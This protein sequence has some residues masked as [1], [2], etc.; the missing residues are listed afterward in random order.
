MSMIS[1]KTRLASTSASASAMMRATSAGAVGVSMLAAVAAVEA[2]TNFMVLPGAEF[3]I[4][5]ATGSARVTYQGQ[6]YQVNAGHYLVNADGSISISAEAA[7]TVAPGL[8]TDTFTTLGAPVD[9]SVL[10]ASAD[11]GGGLFGGNSGLAIGAGVLGLAAV[12]VGGYFLFQSLSNDD[13]DNDSSSGG[14]SGG[15]NAAPVFTS[16][17]SGS[18]AQNTTGTIYT[19]IA[20]D[21]DNDTL[22]YSLVNANDAFSINSSSG[23]VSFDGSLVA[24][25]YATTIR[26][27]D[28]N[29]G[30]TDYA[31]DL[32][33][34]DGTV[35]PVTE[36]DEEDLETTDLSNSTG[37]LTIK[38]D[39]SDTDIVSSWSPNFG[40]NI[41][42]IDLEFGN[43]S[44]AGSTSDQTFTLDFDE[45]PSNVTKVYLD[46]STQDRFTGQDLDRPVEILTVGAGFGTIDLSGDKAV[47]LNLGSTTTTLSDIHLS[48]GM[49][50]L[51]VKTTSSSDVTVGGIDGTTDDYAAEVTLA[52]T[53]SGK[54]IVEDLSAAVTSVDASGSSGQTTV[55][56]L[57]T[58]N[59]WD[60]DFVTVTNGFDFTGGDNV[61]TLYLRKSQASDDVT[62][63]L[64]EG[65]E[66]F[67]AFASNTA[68][69]VIDAGLGT[70]T[71]ILKDDNNSTQADTYINFEA[72]TV[73]HSAGLV[74]FDLAMLKDDITYFSVI[75]G[76]SHDLELDNIGDGSEF[77]YL[78]SSTL[79]A[80]TDITLDA[81]SAG[82]TLEIDFKAVDGG[83]S[84]VGAITATNVSLLNVET[85][86]SL[87]ISSLDITGTAQL[88]HTA[89]TGSG[90]LVINGL[91]NITAIDALNSSGDISITAMTQS[92]LTTY[93]GS[94]G[95]DVVSLDSSA[96]TVSLDTRNGDDD[97][98]LTGASATSV[99][100]TLGAGADSF[101]YTGTGA[102]ALNVSGDEGDDT[103][104]IS[105]S[106]NAA[107]AA[108]YAGGAG[109]DTIELNSEATMVD[110]IVLEDVTSNHVDVTSSNNL[111]FNEDHDTVTSFDQGT[112]KISLSDFGI[113]LVDGTPTILN[114]DTDNVHFMA[115]D[116]VVTNVSELAQKFNSSVAVSNQSAG[117]EVFVVAHLDASNS[118]DPNTSNQGIFFFKDNDGDGQITINDEVT[119]L[120]DF[121]ADAAIALTDFA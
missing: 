79:N 103:I 91:S 17:T 40:A 7:S 41:T 1:K 29:G 73:D 11:A 12:G 58:G 66:T 115:N 107:T 6:M 25:T 65:D 16:S 43:G 45:V 99:T 77:A 24:N 62:V 26:A 63:K 76:S 101:V 32:Q 100:V 57:G 85:N 36:V 21:A 95:N 27:T 118:N 5:Q 9:S 117:V 52:N 34:T 31:V 35:G 71:L 15:S 119:M 14:G 75:G 94:T 67:Y 82:S 104:T 44:N 60:D 28:G 18:I 20:T 13:D 55:G 84:K 97:V 54:L 10:D 111:A 113:I 8:T 98:T 93:S 49:G 47:T 37:T 53:G 48:A 3:V 70:D 78:S 46:G 74:D 33:V 105:A 61:E 64:G 51:T 102:A 83:T 112:D 59:D 69:D 87:E 108:T 2:Q 72:V 116:Q 106:V 89:T 42:A 90:A 109:A 39:D 4:D 50:A 114:F 110:T 88:S 68:D 56:K 96:G 19:A 86:A 22:S 92:A 121:T 38:V 81:T 23:V 80:L 120:G 30:S